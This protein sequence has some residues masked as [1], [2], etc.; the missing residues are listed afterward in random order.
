M[1][2]L[3]GNAIIGLP[4]LIGVILGLKLYVDGFQF[5]FYMALLITVPSIALNLGYYTMPRWPNVA[6]LLIELWILSAIGVTAFATA[7]VTWI[8]LN[9]PL[10]FI[11]NAKML[12]T[13]QAK[14]MTTALISAVTTYV[15]LVWT[16]DIGDAKGVFWPS[17][18]FKKAMEKAYPQLSNPPANGDV[19][20][21]AMF[22][23]V[24]EGY[25]DL[26][27][28]FFARGTR[29]RLLAAAI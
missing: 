16:K 15:A 8:S 6:R 24:V 20:Y 22:T 19:V 4:A 7:A 9:G 3:T 25:G 21:Q 10:D 11:V 14:T 28:T 23:D 26:G 13:D 2:G 12:S 29:A 1:N 27:W 5:L 17:T 18:Q